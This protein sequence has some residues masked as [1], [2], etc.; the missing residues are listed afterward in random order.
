ML[1][2]EISEFMKWF[3]A[4]S[5]ASVTGVLLFFFIKDRVATTRA[6]NLISITHITFQQTLLTLNLTQQMHHNPDTD[7]CKSCQLKVTAIEKILDDQAKQ[8]REEF[9][10]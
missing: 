2:A 5:F 9:R 4:G 3:E 7:E 6:L 1:F 8:L 10:K